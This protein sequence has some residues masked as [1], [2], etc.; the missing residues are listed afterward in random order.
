MRMKKDEKEVKND[1][2]SF[3]AK[4]LVIWLTNKYIINHRRL[5]R[6][7]FFFFLVYPHGTVRLQE[8]WNVLE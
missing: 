6:K 5:I 2:D 7:D 3:D 1:H 8:K 4:I